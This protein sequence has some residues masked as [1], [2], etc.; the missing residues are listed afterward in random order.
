MALSLLDNHS[1]RIH[2]HIEQTIGQTQREEG[3][4]ERRKIHGK[5]WQKPLRPRRGGGRVVWS[6]DACVAHAGG[7]CFVPVGA[8]VGLCGVGTLASPMRT[9]F[10]V[11]R[12][13]ARTTPE[14]R[15]AST[16]AWQPDP[17]YS[18][19]D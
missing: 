2:S 9:N 16:Q 11:E 3:E 13:V 6:G 18:R 10:R 5:S 4:H 12:R 17:S 8:G 19:V 15:Q 7:E 14:L 1:L